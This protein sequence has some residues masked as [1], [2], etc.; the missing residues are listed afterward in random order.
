MNPTLQSICAII[1]EEN[2]FEGIVDLTEA[3]LIQKVRI[4]FHQYCY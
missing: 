4:K 3:E 1:E 2:L